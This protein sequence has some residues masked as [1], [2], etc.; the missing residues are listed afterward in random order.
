MRGAQITFE[1]IAAIDI[2][3]GSRLRDLDGAWVE[4]L[5]GSIKDTGLLNPI[6][7]VRE[8]DGGFTLLAGAHRLAAVRSIGQGDIA[9]QIIDARWIKTHERR[10][11]EIVENLIRNELTKL[12]RAANLSALKDV[13]EILHPQTTRGGDRGNQHTG[14]KKRQSEIFSF[15]QDA[16]EKTGLNKRSIELAVAIWTGLAPDIRTRLSGS[17]IADHQT[18]LKALSGEA[19][20]RQVAVCD[21]LL[22]DPPQAG[23]FGD[24]IAI[25]DKV[26]KPNEADK[27]YA[28]ALGAMN[29]MKPRGRQSVYETFE[30]EIRAFAKT[31]GWLD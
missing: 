25:L 28:S 18:T 19:P 23:S 30:N 1:R 8:K 13:H 15:S 22:S 7:V 3:V 2:S 4:A 20:E 27:I 24:A 17:W 10:V 21:L 29:R 6:T 11:H 14:G 5:A 9:A 26:K 31:K 12:D 16:A